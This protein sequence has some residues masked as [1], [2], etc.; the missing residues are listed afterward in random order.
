MIGLYTRPRALLTTSNR[1]AARPPCAAVLT[2]SA[3]ARNNANDNASRGSPSSA[4][5]PPAS[6]PRTPLALSHGQML[7]CASPRVLPT[8][9]QSSCTATASQS[10]DT[11]PYISSANTATFPDNR[12]SDTVTSSRE[13]PSVLLPDSAHRHHI[14]SRPTV[15]TLYRPCDRLT[16]YLNSRLA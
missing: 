3:C 8:A 10:E 7:S 1:A 5:G 16:S 12:C 15:I 11:Q 14:R 2:L 4:L 6:V 9:R 13:Q